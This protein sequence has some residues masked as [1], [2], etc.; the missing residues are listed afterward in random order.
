MLFH[1]LW[2]LFDLCKHKTKQF[3]WL[4]GDPFLF[5]G[6]ASMLNREIK[7]INSKFLH[8]LMLIG[9]QWSEAGEKFVDFQEF[10]KISTREDTL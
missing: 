8:R 9:A 10:W 5:F 6:S 3:G 2:N 4:D 1:L 7:E